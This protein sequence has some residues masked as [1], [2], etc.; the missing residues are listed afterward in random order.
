MIERADDRNFEGYYV[1]F[2][3][4]YGAE[5]KLR[6]IVER[7]TMP[8]EFHSGTP[9]VEAFFQDYDGRDKYSL[10]MSLDEAEELALVLQAVINTYK[11][12]GE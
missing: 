9:G 3:H 5:T 10:R 4:F 12:D 8:R 2:E 6:V 11:R 1:S 7:L